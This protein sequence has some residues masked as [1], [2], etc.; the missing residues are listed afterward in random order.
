MARPVSQVN[1]FT[2]KTLEEAADEANNFLEARKGKIEAFHIMQDK[3]S[4]NVKLVII[5]N[6]WV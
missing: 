6:Q 2:G 5:T 4:E 3:E 1:V